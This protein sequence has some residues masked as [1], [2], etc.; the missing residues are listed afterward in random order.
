MPLVPPNRRLEAF[1]LPGRVFLCGD[2]VGITDAWQ[3]S[4]TSLYEF[5]RGTTWCNY[6]PSI[7]NVGNIAQNINAQLSTQFH[8]PAAGIHEGLPFSLFNNAVFQ[9]RFCGELNPNHNRARLDIT[10]R[11]LTQTE[12]ASVTTFSNGVGFKSQRLRVRLFNGSNGAVFELLDIF[13]DWTWYQANVSAAIPAQA[14]AHVVDL[15]LG[16]YT[17]DTDALQYTL[18]DEAIGAIIRKNRACAGYIL[19]TYECQR[20]G[21]GAG[22]NGQLETFRDFL[23]LPC[24]ISGVSY[25]VA[26]AVSVNFSTY[27]DKDGSISAAIEQP[28]AFNRPATP[29]LLGLPLA[30]GDTLTASILAG[31]QTDL[32]AAKKAAF[33]SLTLNGGNLGGHYYPIMGDSFV[34]EDSALM[35]MDIQTQLPNQ[36]SG[37]VISAWL[38]TIDLS[39]YGGV[40]LIR[41]EL[42]HDYAAGQFAQTLMQQ[43]YF[44]ST[45]ERLFYAHGTLTP[46]VSQ[47]VDGFVEQV[48]IRITVEK[49][50]PRVGTFQDFLWDGLGSLWLGFFD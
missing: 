48:T 24:P 13:Q 8:I 30:M 39:A 25:R 4:D 18:V 40:H 2:V 50:S 37:Y 16:T 7:H 22:W 20:D 21:N 15:A 33:T 35:T 9:N 44:G 49:T 38:K 3:C 6:S 12:Y 47:A 26:G 10:W 45:G 19:V 28:N 11:F 1:P 32:Q 31:L 27:R 43:V 34:Y 23:P 36:C 17:L 5:E 41:V 46:I 29:M 42:I 14:S